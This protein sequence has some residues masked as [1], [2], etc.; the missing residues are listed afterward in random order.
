MS[1]GIEILKEQPV[2]GAI[3]PT[4]KASWFYQK[5]GNVVFD[6]NTSFAQKVLRYIK[7]AHS[8][9]LVHETALQRYSLEHAA[10]Y[11]A[12]QISILR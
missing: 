3:V 11:I 6:V 4:K 8:P 9:Y 1:D 5:N 12:E 7:N 10:V 2:I